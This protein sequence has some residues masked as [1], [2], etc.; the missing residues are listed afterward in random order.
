MKL[1]VDMPW[2]KNLSVN[3]C[4]MGPRGNWHL[5]REPEAWKDRLGWEIWIQDRADRYAKTLAL[6]GYDYEQTN[7]W[8]IKTPIQVIVNMRFP[9]KRKRDSHNYHY[10]IANGVAAGLHIDDKDIRISTG[11]VEIDRDNPGF[12]I[13]VEDRHD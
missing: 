4:N 7:V 8:R 1:V 12:T 5:K 2:E 9:D 13:M 3:H 10:L 11:T 6:H